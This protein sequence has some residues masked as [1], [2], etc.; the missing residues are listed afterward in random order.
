MVLKHGLRNTKI[1]LYITNNWG[2][3]TKKMTSAWLHP[4]QFGFVWLRSGRHWHLAWNW[5]HFNTMPHVLVGLMSMWLR[6]TALHSTT[7]GRIV[8]LNIISWWEFQNKSIFFFLEIWKWACDKD[9]LI[10]WYTWYHLI[11]PY[12]LIHTWYPVSNLKLPYS[13]LYN[14]WERTKVEPLLVVTIVE[15][16]SHERHLYSESPLWSENSMF[17]F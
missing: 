15:S 7:S 11:P 14:R 1:L 3:F 13:I 12:H 2:V 16:R 9:V 5:A 10:I 8:L 17:M 4:Q 6:C